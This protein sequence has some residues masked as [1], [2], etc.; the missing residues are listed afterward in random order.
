MSAW[1][2]RKKAKAKKASPQGEAE[3]WAGKRK[4]TIPSVAKKISWGMGKGKILAGIKYN[5]FISYC[6]IPIFGL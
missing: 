6:K 2:P 5:F 1:K 4:S 3:N